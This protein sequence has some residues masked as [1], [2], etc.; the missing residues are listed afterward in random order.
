M[1][2]EE[3]KAI[4]QTKLNYVKA[5]LQAA[6]ADPERF[7]K[8]YVAFKTN[9]ILP[10]LEAA[11]ERMNRGI[12]EVCADCGKSIPEERLARAVGALRCVSC[13]SK[14]ERNGKRIPLDES[15]AGR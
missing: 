4:L 13:Q 14:I 2:R 6:A 9:I 1:T 8:E 11:M 10:S 5:S 12:Q 15:N 3:R 7:P